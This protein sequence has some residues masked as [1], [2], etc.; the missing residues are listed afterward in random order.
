MTHLHTGTSAAMRAICATA[1]D[2]SGFVAAIRAAD[3]LVGTTVYVT[4]DRPG[5]GFRGELIEREFDGKLALRWNSYTV[6]REIES[7]VRI[8]LTGRSLNY[9]LYGAGPALKARV[10]FIDE[11][12]LDNAT[13]SG[14]EER[15]GAE[16]WAF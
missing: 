12:Y 1:R 3:S 4:G 8:K 2:E 6:G 7:L 9:S 16:A 15:P 11:V 13:E 10:T 14:Y 5:E